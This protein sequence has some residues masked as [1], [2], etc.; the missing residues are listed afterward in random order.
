MKYSTSRIKAFDNI[1]SERVR[2]DKISGC[3]DFQR[4]HEGKTLGSV[5]R[6]GITPECALPLY[7]HQQ[8][9]RKSLRTHWVP[10][11]LAWIQFSKNSK[12]AR[13]KLPIF[14]VRVR[15]LEFE[16]DLCGF[17]TREIN[18]YLI[19]QMNQL[20]LLILLCNIYVEQNIIY[21]DSKK[22]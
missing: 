14:Q 12:A 3:R 22:S 17:A 10:D 5:L 1:F 16:V 21:V 8:M 9:W 2:R 6:R 19:S 20:H 13:P 18:W 11:N 7:P 15:G 4:D